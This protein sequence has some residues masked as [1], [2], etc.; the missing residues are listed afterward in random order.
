MRILLRELALG[1]RQPD[2][3]L[4]PLRSSY[5]DYQQRSQKKHQH[6]REHMTELGGK[7]NYPAWQHHLP[8][9]FSHQ[10]KP[11]R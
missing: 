4:P 3:A 2:Y 9:P 5:R 6:R 10:R 1:Y 7:R 11:H 8:C